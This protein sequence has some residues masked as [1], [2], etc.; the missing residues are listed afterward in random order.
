MTTQQKPKRRHH[1]VWQQYLRSWTT[2]GAIWCLQNGRIFSTGTPTIALEKD[3][4]K[5]HKLTPEDIAFIK[6]LFADAH[7]LAKR[8]HAHL[9]NRLMTPFQIAEQV[10]R[11]Q[12]RAKI[13]QF[14]DDHY[15]SNVLEDY[16]A[17][18]EAL[19]IPSL[20]SALDGDI[21]FYNDKRCIPFLYYLCTQHMRTRGIKERAIE[22]CNADKSADLSRVW[23]VLIH[24]FAYNVGAGLFLERGRRKL[25][26]VHNRTDVPFI[27]GDQPV[28]NL[29]ANRLYPPESLSIYYP[30]SPQLALLL[31]DVDEK[32]MF[33]TEGL[34]AAQV[35]TL[36][37]KLFEACYKQV[38]ARSE[39]SLWQIKPRELH[40]KPCI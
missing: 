23:N 34:T 35:S 32:P 1:H 5:L 40:L 31:G 2:D 12:D 15:A 24:M 28:I 4:Y 29:K 36:N 19:F 25:V 18:I 21:R 30:I 39:E 8:N 38:F 16:H 3:F 37:G 17:S 14:L 20:K 13:D 7:P 22:R 9:L 26:L 11:P 27:T 33:A 10:K 6:M